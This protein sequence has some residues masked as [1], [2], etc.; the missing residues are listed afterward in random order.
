MESSKARVLAAVAWTGPLPAATYG[1]LRP[2][3]L[4]GRLWRRH[5]TGALLT[6]GAQQPGTRLHVSSSFLPLLVPSAGGSPLSGGEAP[7]AHPGDV[8]PQGQDRAGSYTDFLRL[9]KG[10]DRFAMEY[11]SR[12]ILLAALEGTLV[13]LV[14]EPTSRLVSGG[15]WSWLPS[16][17]PKEK[18][19]GICAP[20]NPPP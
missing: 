15:W 6:E 3:G 7:T 2:K 14:S 9:F 19:E 16:S 18:E 20:W 1:V 5:N 13:G 12:A 10:Q 8:N 11:A 4:K 17:I